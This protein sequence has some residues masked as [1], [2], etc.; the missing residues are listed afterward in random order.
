MLMLNKLE[1]RVSAY[2]YKVLQIAERFL[3]KVWH[4]PHHHCML[5]FS[6]KIHEKKIKQ[7][8]HS[9]STDKIITYR[10]VKRFVLYLLLGIISIIK[11]GGGGDWERLG[12]VNLV[13]FIATQCY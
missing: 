13:L 5:L 11:G 9:T 1:E 8:K 7:T 12:V 2:K 3:S 10:Y 4:L 6:I